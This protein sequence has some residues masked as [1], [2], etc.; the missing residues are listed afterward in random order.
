[1]IKFESYQMEPLSTGGFDPTELNNHYEVWGR[2]IQWVI[3][4]TIFLILSL[5]DILKASIIYHKAL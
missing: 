1:M 5:T 3:R 4:G 2:Q